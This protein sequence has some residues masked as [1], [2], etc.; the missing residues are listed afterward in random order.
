[1]GDLENRDYFVNLFGFQTAPLPTGPPP[2]DL[3]EATTATE[4]KTM[5]T[6]EPRTHWRS[7]SE[8]QKCPVAAD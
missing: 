1:V 5:N 7:K 2:F 6:T 4:S 3:S 8:D